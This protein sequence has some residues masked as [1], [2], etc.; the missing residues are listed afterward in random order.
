MVKQEPEGTTAL[1]PGIHDIAAEVYHADPCPSPSLSS[2]LIKKL[3]R[4][5][6]H[7]W[8]SSP[9]L[10]PNFMPKNKREFDIGKAGHALLLERDATSIVKIGHESYHKLDARRQRDDAYAADRI[11]L[12]IDQLRA[13]RE[14]VSNVRPQLNSHQDSRD[15]LTDGLPELTLTWEEAGIWCRC[16]PDWLHDDR[17]C[18]DDYK[19]M[20]NAH[21]EAAERHLFQIGSDIQAA[22]YMRG[23]RQLGLTRNPQFRFI[24]QEKEPPYALS[25]ME[26]AP[27]AIE[28]AERRIE[29]AIETWRWC[30]KDNT[31]PGYAARTYFISPPVWRE[32][33]QMDAEI[34]DSSSPEMKRRMIDWQAPFPPPTIEEEIL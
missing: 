2:S 17:V 31:W 6:R 3:E 16:R 4:S 29:T 24:C 10:N 18:I 34:R 7:A 8:L 26:F 28:L 13:V 14:M 23:L 9:R 20:A 21:P 30:L 5:P 12:L 19:T 15:A 32:K 11:P 27:A 25:V 1:T 33:Q 22:W